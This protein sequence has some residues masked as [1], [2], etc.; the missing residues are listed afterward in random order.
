MTPELWDAPAAVVPV[1]ADVSVPGSKSL[2]NRWLVLAALAD[3]RSE[4]RRPLVSRDTLLMRDAVRAL[5]VPVDASDD[6]GWVVHGRGTPLGG[7]GEH[8]GV[9]VGN[10]GTVARFVPP[11]AALRAGSTTLDGDP[12]VRE[13]PLAGLVDALRALG[14]DVD[15]AGRGRLPLTVRGTGVL[16]G[17]DVQVDA[18]ASSQIV[19]ALLLAAP[20][21]ARTVRVTARGPVPSGPH[22]R[23]TEEVLRRVGARVDAPGAG[24]GRPRW[25][26]RPGPVDPFEV[27]VEPDLS[28]AAPFLAAAAVTGGRVVVRGWPARTTQPGARLPLL[29]ERLGCRWT[30]REDGLELRGPERLC[31]GL[32]VDLS[33]VG[34]LAPVVAAVAALADAPSVLRGLGHLRGHETD[35]LRALADGLSALGAPSRDTADGALHV[36]PG[37]LHAAAPWETHDDHRLVMAGAVLALRCP[38]LRVGD[39]ATAGKTFPGFAARWE[40]LVADGR[41]AGGPPAETP[42]ENPAEAPAEAGA[43]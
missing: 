18:A 31:G 43:P 2:T 30:S 14:V 11:L 19:S 8:V 1:Q 15:D 27:D 6:A 5:G 42:A 10:A 34:E 24:D 20:P 17:G 29:L 33:D 7:G 12:R 23:M 37:R 39:P 32:D 35:R 25:T 26:V 41:G 16:P 9:D 28:S 40:R 4:L 38:G 22:L 36:V 13:R 3:G 21:A